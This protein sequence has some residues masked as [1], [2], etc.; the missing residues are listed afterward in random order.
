[1]GLD[2]DRCYRALTTRDARFD[3]VFFVG[4]TT[5]GVYCRPVCT[6]RTPRSDRCRFFARAAAAEQ[7]GFRPCLRC[8]PELAPG[9][10]PLEAV[11]RIAQAAAMKIDRGALDGRGCLESLASEL[12]VGS[13][14]LR[15][16][17][18]RELGVSPVRLAQTRRLLLAKQLLT[19]TRLPITEVALASGFESLRRFNASF[20][21]HYRLA[22]RQLR[23][24]SSDT[25]PGEPLR[26]RI[27]YRPPL[28]WD[29]LLRFLAARAIAGVEHIS[30]Q[31]YARSVAIDE[32]QGWLRVSPSERGNAL[33]VEFSDSL[34]PVVGLLLARLRHQFDLAARPD[35]IAEHLSKDRRIGA[36]VRRTPG[37]RVPGAFDGFELSWRAVLGQQVSVRAA[38]TWAGRF[39]RSFGAAIDSP[40]SQLTHLSPSPERIAD[41]KTS[42][43][44][45]IGI[46]TQRAESIRA[47][48][49][50]VAG[51][52]LRLEPGVDVEQTIGQLVELPGIGPWT[53][54][55]IAMRALGWPDAFP[56]SDL[57]L[58]RGLNETSSACIRTVAEAWRP[59]RSYAVMHIWHQLSAR[60]K[61]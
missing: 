45:Q 26:L 41:T 12:G 42:R 6:A 13:R 33:S 25:P 52:L 37:L 35:T 24:S 1:M 16:A 3:G 38:T 56:E 51:G 40:I 8:R 39:V 7:A 18:T 31:T 29:E 19:E 28:A 4:V 61:S 22:P 21:A 53:A 9:N 47:M 60:N 48:A 57:G 20:R 5:T 32:R 23:K 2:H 30:R 54:Q 15:R 59:W 10:S 43:L 44:R 11:G 14:Q 58:K 34:A 49:R 55:Y 46:T 36:A 50:S 27:G 17:V